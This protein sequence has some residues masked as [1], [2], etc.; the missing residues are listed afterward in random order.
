M[1]L[2]KTLLERT[3]YIIL[4]ANLFFALIASSFVL[5]FRGSDRNLV[6]SFENGPEFPFAIF[7]GFIIFYPL[8]F[9]LIYLVV[10]TIEIIISLFKKDGPSGI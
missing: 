8:S 7:L 3:V 9:I 4:I 5:S 2:N 6:F 1:K 10:F